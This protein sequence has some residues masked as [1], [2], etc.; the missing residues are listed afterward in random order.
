MKNTL[1][2]MAR[3]ELADVLA[4]GGQTWDLREFEAEFDLIGY[5]EPT[6]VVAR[7]KSDGQVGTLKYATMRRSWYRRLFDFRVY[8][9]EI[10][11]E[12]SP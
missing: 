10:S 2:Q 8:Q 6:F 5:A 4:H 3:D 1:E 7:R 11:P 9:P 12:R